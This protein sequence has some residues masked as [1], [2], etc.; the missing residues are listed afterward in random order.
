[1]WRNLKSRFRNRGKLRRRREISK[2]SDKSQ[3]AQILAEYYRDESRTT[4]R[5]PR[6]FK[7][8]DAGLARIRKKS[9]GDI[10]VTLGDERTARAIAETAAKVCPKK[11]VLIATGKLPIERAEESYPVPAR[12]FVVVTERGNESGLYA[13]GGTVVSGAAGMKFTYPN[14]ADTDAGETSIKKLCDAFTGKNFRAEYER[15]DRSVTVR[16]EFFDFTDCERFTVKLAEMLKGDELVETLYAY[17]APVQDEYLLSLTRAEYAPQTPTFAR[18]DFYPLL[19]RRTVIKKFIL[20]ED[21]DFSPVADF[22]YSILT[23]ERP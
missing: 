12:A 6:G 23:E 16:Y 9:D 8:T 17:D 21:E 22:I 7:A 20:G 1:M 19:T 3:I 15:Q 13:A 14:D 11:N 4:G 5:L 10:I 18:I 2:I